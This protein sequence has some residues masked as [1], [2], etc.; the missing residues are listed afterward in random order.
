MN[1]RSLRYRSSLVNPNSTSSAR[2]PILSSAQHRPRIVLGSNVR[3]R[4]SL[5]RTTT[6]AAYSHHAAKQ[7]WSNTETGTGFP[8]DGG[9]GSPKSDSRDVTAFWNPAAQGVLLVCGLR[10]HNCNFTATLHSTPIIRRALELEAV[11]IAQ[12]SSE[13]R[14]A[15]VQSNGHRKAPKFD[16]VG[17][18]PVSKRV[19]YPAEASR[20]Q[21]STVCDY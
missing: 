6:S 18:L 4:C 17:R 14:G 19:C 10:S 8:T 2:S 21:V 9:L 13:V 16:D 3:L 12:R 15:P 1:I 5:S 11:A 20:S 7:R